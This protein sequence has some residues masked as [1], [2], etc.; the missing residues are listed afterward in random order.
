MTDSRGSSARPTT[1]QSSA[2]ESE[3]GGRRAVC[4][5]LSPLKII[6]MQTE[7]LQGTGKGGVAGFVGC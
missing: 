2:R 6:F 5:K 3:D 4:G 7:G 1:L